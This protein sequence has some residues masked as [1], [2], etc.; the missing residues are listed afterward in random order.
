MD[1]DEPDDD[2]VMGKSAGFSE[3][4][5]KLDEGGDDPKRP[6]FDAL[7]VSSLELPTALAALP[8][9]S[10]TADPDPD[11]DV[12]TAPT[13]APPTAN[14]AA[15]SATVVSTLGD[16]KTPSWSVPVPGAV[17]GTLPASGVVDWIVLGLTS[18]L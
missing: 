11:T 3:S 4:D 9:V 1:N 2:L 16:A 10:P 7:S 8:P 17:E 13:A 15:A 12:A 18:G 5:V 14:A 6:Q